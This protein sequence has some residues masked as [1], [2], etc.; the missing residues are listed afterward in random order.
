MVPG[1]GTGN[2]NKDQNRNLARK[3]RGNGSRHGSRNGHIKTGFVGRT[4]RKRQKAP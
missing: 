4:I 2:N 1:K 3:M